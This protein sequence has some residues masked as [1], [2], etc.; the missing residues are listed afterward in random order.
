MIYYTFFGCI[1]A[2]YLIATALKNHSI[3]WDRFLSINLLLSLCIFGTFRGE[4]GTDTAAYLR[5]W[6]STR[7]FESF[8]VFDFGDLF[9]EPL[10][11]YFNSYLKY[12]SASPLLFLGFYC[13]STLGLLHIAISRVTPSRL[14][15]YLFYF[16]I[17]LLPYVLNGVRQ[18]MAMSLFLLAVP[19]IHKRENLKVILISLFATLVHVSGIFIMLSYLVVSIVQGTRL[20]IGI[21]TLCAVGTS[22]VVS[23]L[24][25]ASLFL[26]A[27]GLDYFARYQNFLFGELSI[28]DLAYR[29]SLLIYAFLGFTLSKSSLDRQ[30]EGFL[31]S[32]FVIYVL[33]F[34]LYIVFRED[35]QLATRVN[36]FFRVVE[37]MLF[38]LLIYALPR[39]LSVLYA[40]PLIFLG[41]LTL[42]RNLVDTSFVYSIGG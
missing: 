20:S 35:Y 18:G 36:M 11:G 30:Q 13:V 8:S 29:A 34:A 22:L 39:S 37:V 27:I 40:F 15:S 31:K 42:N 4:T 21:T 16:S 26:K 14:L 19:S 12:I 32:L 2:F 24:D 23:S 17:F 6:E 5:I 9:S 25:L 10:F 33:G 7:P 38:P 41:F 3:D 28:V 1:I